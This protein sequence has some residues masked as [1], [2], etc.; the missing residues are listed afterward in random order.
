M[1]NP[2]KSIKFDNLL[3]LV[4]LVTAI[5]VAVV[6]ENVGHLRGKLKTV[7]IVFVKGSPKTLNDEDYNFF[8]E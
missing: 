8:V 4:S 2:K 1:L 7:L 6:G 3:T 5:I